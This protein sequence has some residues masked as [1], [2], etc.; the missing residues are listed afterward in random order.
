MHK[1]LF[2]L[3]RKKQLGRIIARIRKTFGR[4]RKTSSKFM[5]RNKSR[6]RTYLLADTIFHLSTFCPPN[7][8][9]CKTV[10]LQTLKVQVYNCQKSRCMSKK[11]ERWMG[12]DEEKQFHFFSFSF[13]KGIRN[14]YF[15]RHR[16]LWS[17]YALQED[18]VD[19]YSNLTVKSLMLLKWFSQNC[20]PEAQLFEVSKTE[21]LND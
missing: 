19:S 10:A 15:S 1:A 17:L 21:T 18:F 14:K 12:G 9:T 2:L 13:L 4:L 16:T 3:W 6:G 7:L 11:A 5:N 8:E 20:D